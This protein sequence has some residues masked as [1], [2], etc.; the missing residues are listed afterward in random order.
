[1]KNFCLKKYYHYYKNNTL[2]FKYFIKIINKWIKIILLYLY[3]KK[4]KINILEEAI[5]IKKF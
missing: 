5:N 3:K 2:K 1:M 4:I